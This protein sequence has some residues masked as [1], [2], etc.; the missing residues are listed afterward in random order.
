MNAFAV[1]WR[2]AY[3]RVLTYGLMLVA[4]YLLL[5]EISSVLLLAGLAYLFAYLFHPLLVWLQKRRLPRGLGLAVAFLTVLIFLT[6]S[7]VLIGNI[8]AELVQF[9]QKLPRLIQGTQAQINVWLDQLEQFRGQNESLRGAIDQATKAVQ[10]A[11]SRI[12]SSLLGFLQNLGGGLVTRT[13]GVLGG[14]VQFFLVLVIG[15]YMLG[16]FREIGQTALELF[17][18]SWQAAVLDF[19]KDVSTA[20]GGYVRGQL[21]IAGA[22]GVMVGVGLAILGIPLALGLGFLSAVFN[23]VPYLGVIISIA[24]ALLLASQFGL[25]KV[26]LVIVVFIIANQVEAQ[27]LSPNILARTTDLH[28]I[29]VIL[30]ILVGA[31][32]L[33]IFGGL[34][35]VPLVALAKL[36][37]RKHWVGSRLHEDGAPALP[38]PSGPDEPPALPLETSKS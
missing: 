29:T 6:V 10:E 13:L 33:G 20:V 18:K 21:L 4:A 3:V 23:V 1:V 30:T 38:A 22:V 32:L 7:G 2:N 16:S 15:V 28:P 14:V 8:V 12:V 34:L 17:P 19:S 35:A 31:S 9:T 36:L 11:L 27:V 24:P 5:N 26:L 25:V 37:I